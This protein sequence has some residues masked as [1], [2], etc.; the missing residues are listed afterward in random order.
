MHIDKSK[1]YSSEQVNNS[2]F[3][4]NQNQFERYVK[5]SIQRENDYFRE[6]IQLKQAFIF[7]AV[8]RK[9]AYSISNALLPTKK[10]KQQLMMHQFCHI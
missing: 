5:S 2:A 7:P 9:K 1:L 6:T 3:S 8:P 10:M 4:L